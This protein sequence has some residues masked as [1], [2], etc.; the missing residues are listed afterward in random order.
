MGSR[1]RR[2]IFGKECLRQ[3]S[4]AGPRRKMRGIESHAQLGGSTCSLMDQ[5]RSSSIASLAPDSGN[6][7][8]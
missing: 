7:L 5:Q 2:D 3:R 1:R 6:R 4:A 8:V